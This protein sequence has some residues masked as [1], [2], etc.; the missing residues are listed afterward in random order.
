MEKNSDEWRNYLHCI[1]SEAG[2]RGGSISGKKTGPIT[3][4][5]LGRKYGRIGGK[6]PTS[7]YVRQTGETYCRGL[8]NL[9]TELLDSIKDSGEQRSAYI[10]GL[11]L[12][13]IEKLENLQVPFIPEYTKLLRDREFR[14][15]PKRQIT[16]H[17][18]FLERI[19]NLVG[20]RNRAKFITAYL[21]KILDK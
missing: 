1:R 7:N 19:E 12:P 20:K 3:G 13:E 21:T 15:I 17:G 4:P 10:I 8:V 18:H 9:P 2:K 6:T 11:L 14:S 16:L 5:I